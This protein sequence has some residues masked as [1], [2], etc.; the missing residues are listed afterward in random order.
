VARGEHALEERQGALLG[1]Q[2]DGE[3]TVRRQQLHHQVARGGFRSDVAQP[4]VSSAR[5]RRQKHARGARE[6]GI[7][8][9]AL[10]ARQHVEHP[11]QVFATLVV[12][13]QREFRIAFGGLAFDRDG[14]GVELG[15]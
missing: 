10:H 12:H 9:S 6:Q 13:A 14:M 8:V 7:A 5:D 1:L 11:R 3:R 2:C 4:A 15:R